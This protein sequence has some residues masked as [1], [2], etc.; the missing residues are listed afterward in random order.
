MASKITS[1]TS[2]DKLFKGSAKD[3]AGRFILYPTDDKGIM[4]SS[5][6]VKVK[7]EGKVGAW[8]LTV[9]SS[10]VLLNT[11]EFM[12]KR[13][14]D[15]NVT[16]TPANVV[17]TVDKNGKKNGEL[18]QVPNTSSVKSPKVTDAL[19]DSVA[20]LK[21]QA[22]EGLKDVL[23]GKTTVEAFRSSDAYKTLTIKAKAAAEVKAIVNVSETTVIRAE[24]GELKRF[25]KIV[26]EAKSEGLPTLVSFNGR[27]EVTV[28]YYVDD[29]ELTRAYNRAIANQ[30]ARRE[31][32]PAI[33]AVY[34]NGT[35]TKAGPNAAG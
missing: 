16:V 30:T 19:K 13:S 1:G 31:I 22:L 5:D 10:G 34:E 9:A 18:I 23:S 33:A 6:G 2:V 7:R 12:I 25:A 26:K 4:V 21:R 27:G 20:E 24:D 35:V 15:R 32:L 29:K 14:D 11:S 28:A 8:T 17:A 3:D